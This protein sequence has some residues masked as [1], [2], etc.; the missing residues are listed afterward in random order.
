MKQD[1]YDQ[2]FKQ[3]I[4]KTILDKPDDGFTDRVMKALE[5]QTA[6]QPVKKDPLLGKPFWIFVALFAALGIL[7]ILLEAFS[8]AP[9]SS[10]LNTLGIQW[11]PQV[12]EIMRTTVSQIGRE[13]QSLPAALS[14]IML[15]A[16]FLLLADRLWTLSGIVQT[17]GNHLVS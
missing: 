12:P 5:T 13:L 2:E 14:Y 3:L 6:A 16:T 9:D 4:R 17:R 15:T 1:T 7:L 11:Q 10:I 8:P